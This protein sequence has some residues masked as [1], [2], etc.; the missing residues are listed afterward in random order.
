VEDAS[1]HVVLANQY[2]CSMF[3]L[4]VQSKQLLNT[5]GLKAMEDLK[6]LFKDPVQFE[7]RIED[8]IRERKI[9]AG[10]EIAILDGR[11]LER[12]Y[13]PIFVDNIYQG[14]LWQY[15]DITARK[16]AER[17]LRRALEK[18]RELGILRTRFVSTISH[19]FR[20]PLTGVMMSAELIEAYS[21]NM[22]KEQRTAEIQKIKSR[23]D[24][25]VS[26]LNDFLLQSSATT[27]RE[28][29]T[30]VPVSI[31]EIC[32]KAAYE[33]QETLVGKKQR[34]HLDID[35]NIPQT[36]GDKRVLHYILNN[37]LSN[38]S[39]YSDP[40]KSIYFKVKYNNNSDAII[41]SIKDEGIGIPVEEISNLFIPYYR[42]SNVGEITGTGLGLSTVKEFIEL[43]DGTI[44][45]ESEPDKFTLC[46]ISIP[47]IQAS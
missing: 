6:K 2:F 18:E 16:N 15:R 17:E 45:I 7:I 39:K 43:H 3:S 20:T 37:L 38:A 33:I 26:L 8:I 4:N 46:T 30:P 11:T 14:H 25:L 5:D 13:I 47:V 41:I 22:T 31:D 10:E 24:E 40:G 28:R 19:E 34:L 21:E 27:L 29:F 12:D 35:N 36:L 9:V 1:R 32:R 44:T 42:A 23:V